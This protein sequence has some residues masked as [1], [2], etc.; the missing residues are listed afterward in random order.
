MTKMFKFSKKKLV[1]ICV[2]TE[3]AQKAERKITS[4]RHCR[5]EGC[6]IQLSYSGGGKQTYSDPI[7]AKEMTIT[8]RYTVQAQ[9]ALL[10]FKN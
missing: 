1:C 9:I 7:K 10:P 2:S 8:V 3:F 6:N 4:H 5:K